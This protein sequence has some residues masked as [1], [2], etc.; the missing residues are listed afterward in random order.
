MKIIYFFLLLFAP[1]VIVA[2]DPAQSQFFNQLQLFNPAASGFISSEM[3]TRASIFHR[4]QWTPLRTEAYQAMGI[5]LEHRWC[6]G[7]GHFWSL[8][9]QV[10]RDGAKLGY[11]SNIRPQIM[12]SYHMD[13]AKD[14]YLSAGIQGGGLQTSFDPQNLS[15]DAQ[16][17]SMGYQFDV[18]N[19]ENFARTSSLDYD[20]HSGFMVYH[21]RQQ[22]SAGLALHHL[23]RP[24]YSFFTLADNSTPNRLDMG[25]TLHGSVPVGSFNAIRKGHHWKA[26]VMLK[27][28]SLTLRGRQIPDANSQQWQLMAGVE[29]PTFLRLSTGVFVRLAGSTPRGW[30]PDSFVWSLKLHANDVQIGLS[31]DALLSKL[32]FGNRHNGALE[33]NMNYLFQEYNKC[34]VCPY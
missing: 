21:T 34:V 31:Y 8:G 30:L 13:I 24:D 15:F 10:Q 27:K 4:S 28:Q 6:L 3:A 20:L 12:A 23:N 16:F 14:L 7:N 9:A 1:I 22:W 32:G 19:G 17:T 5:S 11:W 2:Q 33:L 25:F 29:T 26:H 18:S